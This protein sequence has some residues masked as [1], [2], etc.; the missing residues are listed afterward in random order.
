MLMDGVSVQT[1]QGGEISLNWVQVNTFLLNLVSVRNN[2]YKIQ[3][4]SNKL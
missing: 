2:I 3:E 1:P 4:F